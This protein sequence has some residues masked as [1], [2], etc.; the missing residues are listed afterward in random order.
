MEN[1]HQAHVTQQLKE[2]ASHHESLE[3]QVPENQICHFTPEGTTECENSPP[4]EDDIQ[5]EPLGSSTNSS[6]LLKNKLLIIKN[7]FLSD[8]RKL[9][10]YV[11][12][13]WSYFE[14]ILKPSF[15]YGCFC[16][17]DNSCQSQMTRHT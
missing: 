8:R 16:T 1:E 17:N 11:N 12:N 9:K 6:R 10:V 7:K 5:G 13:K 3:S 14:L 15:I 2:V 4:I